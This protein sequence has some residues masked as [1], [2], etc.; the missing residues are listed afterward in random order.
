MA[1]KGPENVTVAVRDNGIGIPAQDLPYIFD[2][3]YRV[4]N[5]DTKRIKG[6]GLG[7]AI[8][9][10]IVE[11]HDGRI[12]IDSSPGKGSTFT[13]SLPQLVK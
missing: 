6:T 11:A 3:F 8:S 7:L 9:Q 13:F 5:E 10:S 12:W 4:Q 1:T 2:K